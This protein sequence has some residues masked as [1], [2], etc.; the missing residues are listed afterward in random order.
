M[1][2]DFIDDKL[3]RVWWKDQSTQDVFSATKINE[4]ARKYSFDAEELLL[5]DEVTFLD[6]NGDIVGGVTTD[7]YYRVEQ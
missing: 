6:D 4:M 3:Y 1:T 2:L 5:Q 7:K